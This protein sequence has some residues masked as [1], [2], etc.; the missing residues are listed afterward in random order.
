MFKTL[1][2]VRLKALSQSLFSRVSGSKKSRGPL[3]KL[4][5][6]LLAVYIV[7]VVLSSVGAICYMVGKPLITMGLS[8]LYFALGAALCVVVGMFATVFIAQKQLFE[9]NDNELLLSLPIAPR[10]I[11]ASRLLTVMLMEWLFTVMIMGPIG[12]VYCLLATPTVAG[13]AL[14]VFATV[15]LPF[16]SA[17]LASLIGWLMA[18][19]T[20]RMRRK[21][22]FTT[23][24][25]LAF[26]LLFMYVY[27]S[28]QG[29]ITQLA[30]NGVAVAEAIRRTVPMLYA[31]GVAV[32]EHSVWQLLHLAAWCLIPF[33]LMYVLL[34]R[35]FIRIA[36]AKHGG[37][38]VRYKEKKWRVSTARTALL[39]KEWRFFFSLPIYILNC[40]LGTVIV[41]VGCV[42]MLIKKEEMASLL[43]AMPGMDASLLMCAMLCM[44]VIMTNTAS[45]ALS[46]E[47]KRLW[48]IRS[49]PIR[50]T[51]VFFSKVAV[52][53]LIGLPG[54]LLGT[55]V[56][57]AV[58][59]IAW[60]EVLLMLLTALLVLL[61]EA[62]LG[63]T[64]NLLLP[65]FDWI[66]ETA[67]IK[68]SGSVLWTMLGS[69]VAVLLP[70][71]TYA[72]WLHRFVGGTAFMAMAAALF[73]VVDAALIL[74]LGKGGKKRFE[75]RL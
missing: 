64:V 30:A 9:A 37:I 38:R 55:A 3:F 59:Q 10:Y 43:N 16:L 13:I 74:Y 35:S 45:C 1:M 44:G 56:G 60:A 72:L 39:K 22:I 62:L 36:T 41:V 40:S 75:K 25:M 5:I 54:V 28:A 34:S 8:W 14:F 6:G 27:M 48:I 12:V 61:F 66:D 7:F 29:Y 11:L 67:V 51:D 69:F 70:G 32:A 21:N 4:L 63:M 20:S 49:S 68:Q 53:V 19:I 73:V 46:L 58:W 57:W 33:G 23:V 18:L 15:L 71:A 2:A 50:V 52:N 26:V 17:A 31:F 24:L 65:R 42:A 47:G